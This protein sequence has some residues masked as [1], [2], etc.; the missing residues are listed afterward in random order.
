MTGGVSIRAAGL[1][2]SMSL[3]TAACGFE[4][5]G[6]E[7][8]GATS[9]Q[10]ESNTA[11]VGLGLWTYT[12]SHPTTSTGSWPGSTSTGGPWGGTSTGGPW[13]GTTT[14]TG[15]TTGTQSTTGT[16]PDSGD[17]E[18]GNPANAPK[19]GLV[20]KIGRFD[21]SDPA[22]PRSSWPGTTFRT[23]LSGSAISV[24]LDGAPNV[25][26]QIEIDGAVTGTLKTAGG[27]H[28]YSVA[29]GLPAGQH[30]VVLVRRNEG[31]FGTVSFLGF[32]PEGGAS[33]V[34]SPWPYRH[35]L[36]LIGDSLTCGFGI[37]G[38]SSDCEF[39]AAT[40]S[41]YGAYGAVAARSTGAAVHV[42]ATS[43][44]GVFQNSGGGQTD[45]M[46]DLWLRTIET[47]AQSRW[48]FSGF[49]PEAV[50][51]NLGTNDFSVSIRESD[52]VRAYVQLLTSVRRRYP[53]AKIF[54][55][56]WA[57]WGAEHEGWV[58]TAMRDSGDRNLRHLAFRI[59]PA[60]GYG[61][62]HHTNLATNAKL[63][64]LLTQALHDDL[65]W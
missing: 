25:H 46:P 65:G 54:C 57:D 41:C 56:S 49:V 23:R 6:G 44:K 8:D 42:I 36:E 58:E 7:G 16:N 19:R 30:D 63:G 17:P 22:R 12:F 9:G 39:S 59:E 45:T 60:D 21:E 1:V 38:Q 14:P 13:G 15:S 11:S 53:A 33:L 47:D 37:E 27:E 26:F 61:C 2:V 34:E 18:A 52:F 32:V 5:T 55:V 3:L 62:D 10:G 50:V 20:H 40:E 31:F 24:K 29:T 4:D 48:A 51:I 28:L 35:T 64:R 43:G